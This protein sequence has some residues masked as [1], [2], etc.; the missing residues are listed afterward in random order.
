MC[1]AVSSRQQAACPP[2]TDRVWNGL[3]LDQVVDDA[4]D[5]GAARQPV[6]EHAHEHE[7]AAADVPRVRDLPLGQHLG[8]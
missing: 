1:Q 8:T 5:D 7:V 4:D 6:L 3:H 2:S